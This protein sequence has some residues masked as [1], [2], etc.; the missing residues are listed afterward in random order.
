MKNKNWVEEYQDYWVNKETNYVVKE[1]SRYE[2]E[3]WIF[4]DDKGM[5]ISCEWK[6]NKEDCME[7]ADFI[8]E[9]EKL[10]GRFILV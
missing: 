9:N 4:L 7:E 3:E 10:N 1:I 6:K 8:Y 5:M 2:G